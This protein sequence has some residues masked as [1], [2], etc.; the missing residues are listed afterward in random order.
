MESVQGGL[1]SGF[2]PETA[3]KTVV[4]MEELLGTNGGCTG[5]DFFV[6]ELL[7]FSNGYSETEE[8]QEE[9]QEMEMGKTKN[10][11]VSQEK[12]ESPPENSSLSG[13]EDFGSLHESEVSVQ[14]NPSFNFF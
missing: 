12:Q 6:D 14:V 10:S 1:K 2:G 9:P 3:E 11:P 7:D 8:Q 13:K 5:D 4:N